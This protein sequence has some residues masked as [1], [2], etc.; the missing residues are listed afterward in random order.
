MVLLLLVV[1]LC[2]NLFVDCC[3][4]WLCLFY[5]LLIV[6]CFN[7]VNVSFNLC[8]VL[9]LVWCILFLVAWFVYFCDWLSVVVGWLL[10]LAVR[11]VCWFGLFI[12]FAAC[13]CCF[14][15]CCGFVSL[16]AVLGCGVVL[17]VVLL[18]VNVAMV[19]CFSPLVLGVWIWDVGVIVVCWFVLFAYL[20]YLVVWCFADCV[21][22]FIWFVY[23]LL[24]SWFRVW[25]GFP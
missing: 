5:C 18:F 7:N 10:L 24:F 25:L 22:L 21:L 8:L 4:L 23:C 20:L 13:L 12:C 6:G 19:V 2:L 9:L 3:S 16:W 17:L 1:C 14:I 11:V 15:C